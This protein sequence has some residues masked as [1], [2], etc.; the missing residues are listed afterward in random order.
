M[1]ASWKMSTCK[2]WL[3]LKNLIFSRIFDG[4]LSRGDGRYN[5][6]INGD[7]DGWVGKVPGTDTY[8]GGLEQR[9][10]NGGSVYGG[11]GTNLDGDVGIGG[12]YEREFDNGNGKFKLGGGVNDNGD[13]NFGASLNWK[14]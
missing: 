1:K 7:T 11:I 3:H 4:W 6:G 8:G 9:L 13:Y 5:K 10:P 2:I 14:F 12:G